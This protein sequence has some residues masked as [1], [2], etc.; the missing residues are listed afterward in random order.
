MFEVNIQGRRVWYAKYR[1]GGVQSEGEDR[2]LRDTS[3]QE[4]IERKIL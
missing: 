4:R 2:Y 1:E 3:M